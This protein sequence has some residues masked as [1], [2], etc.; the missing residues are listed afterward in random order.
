MLGS[1]GHEKRRL[2][3]ITKVYASTRRILFFVKIQSHLLLTEFCLKSD[4]NSGTDIHKLNPVRAT[5]EDARYCTGTLDVQGNTSSCVG[6]YLISS[7]E[8]WIVT[9][10]C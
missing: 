6:R 1:S 3:Y 4:P 2:L 9:F 7:V 8:F 10:F 5:A